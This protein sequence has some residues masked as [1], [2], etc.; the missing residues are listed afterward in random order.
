M[1]RGPEYVSSDEEKWEI[2]H[3]TDP[4]L[5]NLLTFGWTED[6]RCGYANTDN[7]MQICPR[8]AQ[9]FAHKPDKSGKLF[10]CKKAAAGSRHTALLLVNTI[11]EPENLSRKTKK[12]AV[13]GLNQQGLCEEP[14]YT[15]VTDL[16]AWGGNASSSFS[17]AAGQQESPIDV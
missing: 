7:T 12:V 11:R 16:P 3:T 8:P 10:V 14:G 9:G 6:G 13:I 1:S 15:Q 4:P 2:Q 17:S 5:T